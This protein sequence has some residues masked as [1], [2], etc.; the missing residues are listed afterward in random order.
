MLLGREATETR[1]HSNVRR[2]AVLD[3]SPFRNPLSCS[4]SRAAHSGLR[5]CLGS[6]PYPLHR[7]RSVTAP[8]RLTCP[9]SLPP[10][11]PL[12][13]SLSVL[14]GYYSLERERE[15]G[16]GE[17][18]GE[19]KKQTDSQTDRQTD[20]EGYASVLHAVVTVTGDETTSTC[21]FWSRKSLSL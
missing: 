21:L 20:R 9:P 13:L 11:P 16:G 4:R 7:P 19:G 8:F 1:V 12:S 2:G 15:R 10:P 18:E 6:S 17:G 14:H 5:H 3:V